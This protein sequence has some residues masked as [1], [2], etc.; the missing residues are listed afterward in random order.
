ADDGV[1]ARAAIDGQRGHAGRQPGS[2][3]RVVTA[4]RIDDEG[5]ICPFGTL[6]HDIGGQ[7][8]HG[9]AAAA[10]RDLNDVGVVG[11]VEDNRV[12]RAV[13]GA[14]AGSAG[15]VEVNVGDSSTVQVVDGDR[16]GA[17]TRSDVD[18]LDAVDIHGYVADVAGEKESS[19][20]RRQIELLV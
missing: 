18:L 2:V 19:A 10:A 16:I 6:N 20:I 9:V 4:K 8:G 17:A 12:G 5:V 14:G 11:A 13:T 15:E 3:Y 1:I 7:P